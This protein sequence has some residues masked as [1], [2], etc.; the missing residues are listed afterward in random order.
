MRTLR[1]ITPL[2][3][4]ILCSLVHVSATDKI[5]GF[6]KLAAGDTLQMRFTSG[7]CFHFYTYDVTFTRK[8]KPTASV[9]AVRQ[10]WVGAGTGYRDAERQELGELRLSKS[11]LSGLDAL[12]AFYR[13]NTNRGCT[14]EDSIKISQIR[15]GKVIATEEFTDASCR[16]HDVKGVLTIPSLARRLPERKVKK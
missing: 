12:L 14:T 3:S 7:G 2:V 5:D 13:S 11:D 1:F 10:E 16:A 6:T 9:A 8:A 4:A 15:D